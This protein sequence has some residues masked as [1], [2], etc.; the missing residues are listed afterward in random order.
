MYYEYDPGNKWWSSPT[1][2]HLMDELLVRE[3]SLLETAKAM[4]P[5]VATSVP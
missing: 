5:S 4:E 1:D 2:G 3:N